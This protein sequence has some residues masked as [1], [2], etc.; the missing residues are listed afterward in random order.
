MKYQ[1][2][3]VQ[4]ALLNQNMASFIPDLMPAKRE[5]GGYLQIRI[6]SDHSLTVLRRRRGSKRSF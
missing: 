3:A 5:T 4:S 6:Q 2:S 1:L